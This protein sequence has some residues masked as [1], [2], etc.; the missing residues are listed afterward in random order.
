[1]NSGSNLHQIRGHLDADVSLSLEHLASDMRK[2]HP[3]SGK[4][5]PIPLDGGI[6][7]M[8]IE[9]FAL[10]IGAFAQK[11]VGA[12]ADL[13]QIVGPSAVAGKCECAAVD[14]DPHRERY[15][16]FGMRRTDR[17]HPCRA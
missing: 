4:A 5:F 10:E 1:M 6:V 11:E 15:V 17:G 8:E 7:E 14:R 9:M 2:D 13:K 12:G 16:G 3:F